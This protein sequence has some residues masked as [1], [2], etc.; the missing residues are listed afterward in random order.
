MLDFVIIT[1]PFIG[2]LFPIILFLQ[3]KELVRYTRA[4]LDL[5]IEKRAYFIYLVYGLIMLVGLLIS[6]IISIIGIIDF[7]IIFII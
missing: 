7:I 3:I 6:F 4:E 5:G 2:S 1:V